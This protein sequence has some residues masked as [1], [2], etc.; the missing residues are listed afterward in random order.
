MKTQTELWRH[1]DDHSLNVALS[2]SFTFNIF[3]LV[4]LRIRCILGFQRSLSRNASLGDTLP[5]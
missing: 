3:S 4:C 2:K 1:K 5:P